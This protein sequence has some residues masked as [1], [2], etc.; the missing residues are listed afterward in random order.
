MHGISSGI[1]ELEV[2]ELCSQ[3]GL[4]IFR[5]RSKDALPSHLAEAEG[6]DVSSFTG[7]HRLDTPRRQHGDE[8]LLVGA[9]NFLQRVDAEYITRIGG[10]RTTVPLASILSMTKTGND[11]PKKTQDDREGRKHEKGNHGGRYRSQ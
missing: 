9:Q 6:R 3:N 11:G 5:V 7:C 2:L 4:H 1:P 10:D 8:F